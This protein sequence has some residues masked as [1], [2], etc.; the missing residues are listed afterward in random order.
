MYILAYYAVTLYWIRDWLFSGAVVKFL[1]DYAQRNGF[2]C[3]VYEV[4]PVTQK[5]IDARGTLVLSL[6]VVTV[7]AA[8]TCFVPVS[9]CSL[10]IHTL[11]LIS[12]IS[13]L[14]SLASL[15]LCLPAY[16]LFSPTSHNQY[17]F[18]LQV[19]PNRP[20]IIMTVEGKNPAIPTILLNSHTDVVPVFPVRTVSTLASVPIGRG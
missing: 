2:Q 3:R 6:P 7:L 1:E 20:I 10:P 14:F 16:F 4:W 5:Y 17:K 19:A 12:L 9:A 18:L 15:C 8:S 11:L 13:S